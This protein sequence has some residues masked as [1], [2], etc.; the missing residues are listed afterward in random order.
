[1][2][3]NCHCGAVSV[4]IDS[5]PDFINECN[6]SLCRKSGGAWGYFPTSSVRT[7]GKTVFFSRNDKAAP[8]VEIHACEICAAT[9]HWV[10]T[11]AFREQN[12]AIDQMG[13][14]MR[15]FDPDTLSGVEVRFPNGRDWNG[16]SDFGYRRES[17]VISER[18]RW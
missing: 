17:F 18:N 13:V 5:K 6:C 3:A 1:M 16:E 9:T 15:L 4:A 14:N 11:D 10:L 2:T 12:P 7:I 8:A